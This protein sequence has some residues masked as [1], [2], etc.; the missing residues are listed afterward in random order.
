MKRMQIEYKDTEI[1]TN[2]SELART[3]TTQ[4]VDDVI[5]IAYGNKT[6]ETITMKCGKNETHK[7]NIAYSETIDNVILFFDGSVIMSFDLD[8]KL[9]DAFDED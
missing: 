9:I 7:I 6:Y 4:L 2:N 1:K 3:L 5:N 8:Y